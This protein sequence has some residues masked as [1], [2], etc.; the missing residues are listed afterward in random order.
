MI[1]LT[2]NNQQKKRTLRILTGITIGLVLHIQVFAQSARAIKSQIDELMSAI[3]TEQVKPDISELFVLERKLPV[4]IEAASGYLSDTTYKIRLEAYKITYTV[5]LKST[6]SELKSKTLEQFTSALQDQNFSISGYCARQLNVFD[7]DAF[8]SQARNNIISAIGNG[9]PGIAELIK[10]AGYLDLKNIENQVREFALSAKRIEVR[11]AAYLALARMGDENY[12]N[13][14]VNAVRKQGINDNVVYELVPDLIY[15]RQKSCV[16]LAIEILFDEKK[17]CRSSDP[18]NPKRMECGYRVMEYLAPVI[19]D[20]PFEVR[21]SGDID[22]D[23]YEKALIT[24]RE[25]FLKKGNSYAIID[26][27]Y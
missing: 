11:W 4:V 10:M 8:S 12:A 27:S 17:N 15:T 3:R 18:D 20:F 13:R 23:N 24:A 22:T 14:V 16:D 21:T 6:D 7:R 9:I 1:N 19:S 25:W 26:N 2:I 5:A